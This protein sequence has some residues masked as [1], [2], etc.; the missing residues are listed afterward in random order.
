MQLDRKSLIWKN[1]PRNDA[2]PH[3]GRLHGSSPTC[4]RLPHPVCCCCCCCCCVFLAFFFSAPA[5]LAPPL[6]SSMP[7]SRSSCGWK[8]SDSILSASSSTTYIMPPWQAL[9]LLSLPCAAPAPPPAAA[10]RGAPAASADAFE[11]MRSRWSSTRSSRRP[12]VATMMC[13]CLRSTSTCG[14]SA[15]GT[16]GRGAD[17][18]PLTCKSCTRAVTGVRLTQ[19]K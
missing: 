5:L 6:G 12:G 8:P 3:L 1:L 17:A 4:G 2:L 13:G 16:C 14:S 10:S 18:T 15:G 7:R 11:L 9:L 19:H